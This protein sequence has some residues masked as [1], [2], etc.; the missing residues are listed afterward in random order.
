MYLVPVM[1]PPEIATQ[2]SGAPSSTA[3]LQLSSSPLQVSA[4]PAGGVAALHV[5][6]SWVMLHTY[7]PVVVHAP[8]P[9]LHAR[10]RLVM[11]SSATPSQSLSRPSQSASGMMLPITSLD[12]VAG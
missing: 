9:R 4:L 6:P 5:V 11:A 3:P 1:P 8:M 2:S 12:T 7:V 10:P